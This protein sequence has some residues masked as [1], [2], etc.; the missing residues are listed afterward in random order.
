MQFK[1]KGRRRLKDLANPSQLGDPVSLKAETSDSSPTDDDR[2]AAPTSGSV[3][4][5]TGGQSDTHQIPRDGAEKTELSK[6]FKD[7][8]IGDPVSLEAEAVA[9]SSS[10]RDQ[11]ATATSPPTATGGNPIL[12]VSQST[13]TEASPPPSPSGQLPPIP[14]IDVSTLFWSMMAHS[15]HPDPYIFPALQRLASLPPNKKPLLGALSNTITFPSS[16][17]YHNNPIPDL[18]P[19]FSVFISSS[20][21]GM[22][23]P[24]PRI[25]ELAIQR[26]DEFDRKHGGQGINARNVLFLDDIGENLKVAKDICGIR[27]LKVMRGKTWRAVKELERLVGEGVELMDEK[28]RKAKL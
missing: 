24:D 18:R 21:I 2:G 11:K 4:Q 23:K 12:N 17:P 26:L 14:S 27:T 9:V 13:K 10:N 1:H 8:T 3:P 7:T 25:Y 20:E 22:R 5:K 15:R 28:T 19:Y 6:V 16:H